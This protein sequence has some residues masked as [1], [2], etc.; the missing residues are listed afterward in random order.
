MEEFK[1]RLKYLRLTSL[2]ELFDNGSDEEDWNSA[3]QYLRQRESIDLEEEPI[4]ENFEKMTLNSNDKPIDT[5]EEWEKTTFNRVTREVDAMSL[6]DIDSFL[7]ECG[8]VNEK[9]ELMKMLNDGMDNLLISAC[10]VE[11]HTDPTSR[12]AAIGDQ[13]EKEDTVLNRKK[14][15]AVRKENNQIINEA[16]AST[17]TFET[18]AVDF[19]PLKR[20]A[21]EIRY[22][23]NLTVIKLRNAKNYHKF[24]D[25]MDEND[26]PPLHSWPQ[27]LLDI[28]LTK[29][30]DYQ[31]R[32]VLALFLHGNGMKRDFAERLFLFYNPHYLNVKYWN[33]RVQKFTDLF[34]Y[35]DNANDPSSNEYLFIRNKYYYFNVHA[36]CVMYYDGYVRGRDGQKIPYNERR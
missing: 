13:L 8:K 18:K 22:N 1:K 32:M 3:E 26:F 5:D 10:P 17:S 30:F 20:T 9:L 7:K 27:Y 33:N 4:K 19:K 31:E 28:L 11:K 25:E 34:K 21:Q 2:D 29:C 36:G 14:L 35:F 16:S 12:F 6:E 23:H 15:K 24:E